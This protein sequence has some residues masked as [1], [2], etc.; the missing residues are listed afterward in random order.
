[1]TIRVLE[2]TNWVETDGSYG[3][4]QIITWD[5]GDLTEAQEEL[6]GNL[7]DNDRLEYVHA[8]MSGEPLDEW[9]QYA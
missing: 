1:M 6:L 8:I 3:F 4:S 9:E 5:N 2:P 7:P